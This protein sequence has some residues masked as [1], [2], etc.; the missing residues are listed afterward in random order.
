MTPITCT[1]KTNVPV[2]NV[3]VGSTEGAMLPLLM[4]RN[5]YE[6]MVNTSS[7]IPRCVY[8]ANRWRR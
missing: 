8:L 1:T 7:T 5:N 4:H 6:K 2:C 3:V